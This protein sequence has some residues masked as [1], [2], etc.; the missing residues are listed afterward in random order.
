LKALLR[1][2]YGSLL[3][4]CPRSTSQAGRFSRWLVQIIKN[5]SPVEVRSL[6][7]EW[8]V[9]I[10]GHHVLP[11]ELIANLISRNLQ[12]LPFA[13]FFEETVLVPVPRASLMQKDSLWPSLNIARALEKNG[14]G[15]CRVLLR[16][17]KPIRRSSLVPAERRP[18]PLEHYESMSVEKMLTVPTSVV[19]VDDILT[20]GHTFLGAAWRL[21]EAFPETRIVGVCG[22]A[23]G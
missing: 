2:E 22:G 8:V 19:L 11:S 3:S 14:L 16:R 10:T 1:L 7:R 5:E 4:Y 20:R 9:G 6:P 23:H 13:W 15:E 21:Q 18:K 17:V 12:N